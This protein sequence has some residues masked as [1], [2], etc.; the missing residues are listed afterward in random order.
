MKHSNLE[1]LFCEYLNGLYLIHCGIFWEAK[2]VDHGNGKG[3]VDNCFGVSASDIYTTVMGSSAGA[4]GGGEFLIGERII[5][6]TCYISE[7]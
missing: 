3:S 5:Q 1:F 7:D 2:A 4:A 6:G